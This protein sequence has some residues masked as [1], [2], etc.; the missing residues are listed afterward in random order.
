MK[1]LA[2]ILLEDG[3]VDEAQLAAA[4]DEHQRAGR[5]L[6]RVLVEHGVLTE[7]QL[8]A[9]LAQQIGL[10]FVD[11]TEY[12]VDGSA[13]ARVPAAVS[14][15]AHRACPIGS[16]GR[17]A[18]RG[19]GRPGQR[20]RPRRHPLDHRAGRPPGGR[21]PRRRARRDRPVLPRRRRPGRPHGRDGRRTD[22]DDDLV[23]GHGDRRGRA[24]RQVRQPADHPGDPGPR[25][26]HPHRADR[27]RPAGALPHRRRAAR[28]H[29]LAAS[30]PVRRHLPAED[31]GRHRHRRA[32]H[33]AGR[34]A[35]GQ[36]PTAR[37]STCAWRPCRRCGAR[38]SSCESWTTPRPG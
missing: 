30:D 17:P 34:P 18:A 36:P 15:A 23:Q 11:L 2:D 29:A 38:R 20:L 3:L 21:H 5:S 33:P 9:A 12:P 13:I 6:G 24:D 28:G 26:R 19:H 7:A 27:A 31:H 10:P 14:P 32:P 16:R 1:Q 22:D 37:R 4:F 35:V 25:L 8:V